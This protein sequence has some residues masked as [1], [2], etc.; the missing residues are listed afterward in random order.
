VLSPSDPRAKQL[1]ETFNQKWPNWTTQF[2]DPF[3]WVAV[4]GAAALMGDRARVNR[5]IETIQT[6]YVATS[7]PYPWYCAEAG[8]FMRVNNYML[9]R[10][11][12]ENSSAICGLG[13]HGS[14]FCF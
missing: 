5:Y 14:K 4:S 10:G 7:F 2:A 9:H 8:W 3:P 6:T 13:D 12:F 11:Q 1:Y